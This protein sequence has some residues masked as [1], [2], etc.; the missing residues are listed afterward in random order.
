MLYFH[1]KII[2]NRR[3]TEVVNNDHRDWCDI[4][5]PGIFCKADIV[6]ICYADDKNILLFK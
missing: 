6:L 5:T 2:S 3:Y 4:G 1:I